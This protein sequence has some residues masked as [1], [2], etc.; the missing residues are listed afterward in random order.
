ME[1]TE[2]VLSLLVESGQSLSG[3]EMAAKLGVSRNSVWKAVERLREEGYE[4]EARTNRGYQLV[5]ESGVLS[6]ENVRRRLTGEAKLAAIS[7][8]KTVTSTNTV[9]KE[10]AEQGGREGMVVIAE[11]QTAGKGRLGRSFASPK[12]TGLY[13]SILLRPKFSAEQSLSIT[14]AAAVAV[15]GAV[16]TVTGKNAQI[17]WVND[18]YLNWR[19]ICGILTEASVDFEN[20]GLRYAVLGIGVNVQE[21]EDGFPPAIRDI[22]GALYR[23]TP[24]SGSRVK[25]AA[26]ILN[27]F[28]SFYQQMPERPFLIEYRKRS[29]LT[30][31]EITFTKGGQRGSGVVLDVDEEARLVVQL[32]GEKKIALSAGEVEIDKGFLKRLRQQADRKDGSI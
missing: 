1:L 24:P 4:I 16:E 11:Q 32:D 30:G 20:G 6:A 22:A 15:A 7:V 27:R 18:V 17:K 29:L 23:E 10:T 28:F 21:P 26:E 31:L 25:L 2:A 12:G 19:K 5:S 14:T 9:M 3:A 13:M 8:R